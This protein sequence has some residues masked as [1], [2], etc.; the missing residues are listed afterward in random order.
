VRQVL[1]DHMPQ[2][3]FAEQDELFHTFRFDRLQEPLCK[4][5]QVWGVWRKF[6]DRDTCRVQ[7]LVEGLGVFGV[8]VVNQI[9]AGTGGGIWRD[10][11]GRQEQLENRGSNRQLGI[12]RA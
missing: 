2:G 5:I 3:V 6:H 8:A 10:G 12:I 1:P 9:G 11:F 4:R 7:D